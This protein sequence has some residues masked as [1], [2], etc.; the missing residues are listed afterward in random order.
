[1]GSGL[2]GTVLAVAPMLV[3]GWDCCGAIGRP[4]WIKKGMKV[5]LSGL[6]SLV[7][8]SSFSASTGGL[9]AITGGTLA[10]P[11]GS[12][13]QTTRLALAAGSMGFTSEMLCGGAV[14]MAISLALG[15]QFI[16]PA[17]PLAAAAWA[18]LVVFGLL[19]DFN[20]YGYLLTH[21]AP[22][23]TTRY[24]FINPVIALFLGVI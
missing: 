15:E 21:A 5:G 12:I 17:Q 11:L 2:A 4:D 10:W 18:Y 6:A 7:R 3:S 8:G 24:A 19:I 16:W 13:M 14:L 1:M 22:A 9:L 23:L 20:A